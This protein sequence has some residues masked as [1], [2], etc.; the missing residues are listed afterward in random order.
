MKSIYNMDRVLI[1]SDVILDSL[2]D[3]KP[4]AKY[5]K[6]VLAMSESRK[7]RGFLTPLIYS[8]VYYLLRR[9]AKHEKII[10]K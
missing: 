7:I 5:S 1:D 2:F 6:A 4:F 3:R 8:N 10:E 9:T